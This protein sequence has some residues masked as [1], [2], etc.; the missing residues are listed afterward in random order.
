[1]QKYLIT[2]P[3]RIACFLGTAFRKRAGW[4]RWRYRY[5]ET[6]PRTRL[7]IRR[8]NIW[9]H[10]WYGRGLLQLTNPE[11]YFNYFSF[12]GRA[13][14]ENIRNTLINEYS[15]LYAQQSLRYT[16]N[17]LSDTENHVPENII[18]W[19]NNVSSDLHEAATAVRVLLG[20][21]E[22]GPLRR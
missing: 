12:R 3:L 21:N 8:Y 6:D 7:V 10:P 4:G 5:T 17:H 14:P 2:T 11:N 20:F 9:Y 22:Y 1:M 15:R 16:D 18:R 19:R 13:C